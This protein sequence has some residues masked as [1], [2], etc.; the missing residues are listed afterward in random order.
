MKAFVCDSC[1]TI[2][3]DPYIVKMKEYIVGSVFDLTIMPTK[4]KRRV[5]I[6]LCG[7]C[8]Q[9]LQDIAKSKLL[10]KRY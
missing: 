9:S 1:N 8:F 6:H 3:S 4:E 7:T 10:A 2:I 5:K